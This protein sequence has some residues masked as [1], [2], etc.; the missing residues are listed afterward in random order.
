MRES[1]VRKAVRGRYGA[2]AVQGGS[3]CG[4]GSS[5]CGAGAAAGGAAGS[6]TG[7]A[8]GYSREEVTSVPTGSDLGLGC[9]NPLALAALQGGETV[10]DL[11]SGAGFDCFLAARRVGERGRVIG[12]DMTPRDAGPGP[13]ERPAGRL[14][15]CRVPPG[16]DR[17]PAG[18]G[19]LGGPAHLQLRDQPVGRQGAGFPGSLPGAEEGRQA[20]HLRYR[21]ERGAACGRT[22]FAGRLCRLRG[23][24]DAA[25]RSTW[26]SSGKPASSR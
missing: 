26:P 2:V 16:R 22:G 23:R 5:C 18:G 11:G 7:E 19:R 21:A 1:E 4:G 6:A 3:C 15:E 25:G 20:G 14:H 8:V 13:G 10:L 17:E 12:V 24:G 9:G